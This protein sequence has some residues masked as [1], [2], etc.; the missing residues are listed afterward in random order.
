[1]W[2]FSGG[3]VISV[4]FKI[5]MS[6]FLKDM[7]EQ[8]SSTRTSKSKQH[9]L[10]TPHLFLVNQL[11]IWE[12]VQTTCS[13]N[14]WIAMSKQGPQGML[15]LL[16]HSS[17]LPS[18]VPSEFATSYIPLFGCVV[19]CGN[20]WIARRNQAAVMNVGVGVDSPFRYQVWGNPFV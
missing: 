9:V 5:Y 16:S 3:C 17:F 13:N 8:I 6:I 10:E 1:M 11:Q 12:L 18:L 2:E 7:G 19:W 15:A 4:Y 20:L 14:L